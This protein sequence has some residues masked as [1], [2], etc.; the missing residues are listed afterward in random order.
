MSIVNMRVGGKVKKLQ[1][2][3]SFPLN[4]QEKTATKNGEV[5]ADEGYAGLSK[6]AVNVPIPE[7]YIKP[8]GTKT[9]TANGTHDVSG[10]ASA[11]VNV[12]TSGGGGT[13][14]CSGTHLI[15]VTE[16]PTEN[17]D[18]NAVYYIDSGTETK[19]FTDVIMINSGTA[20]SVRSTEGLKS[21]YC[22]TK[23]TE[24]LVNGTYYYV[25]DEDTVY[26]YMSRTLVDMKTQFNYLGVIS[27]ASQA[28][29]DVD[30]VYVVITTTITEDLCFY[31]KGGDTVLTDLVEFGSSGTMSYKELFESLGATVAIHSI[32]TRISEGIL[33]STELVFNLYYIQN[34]NVA[35]MFSGGQWGNTNIPISDIVSNISEVPPVEGIY[36]IG[37]I[38]D[39]SKYLKPS[40]GLDITKNDFYDVADKASVS[41]KI[42]A[43]YVVQTVADL[44]D[45]VLNGDLAIVLS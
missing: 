19:S 27:S 6:V 7:G 29:T 8:T 30:G 34:E 17:I 16:L 28:S 21:V 9:I 15:E 26:G 37:T 3:E 10:Y 33:E 25:E 5:V 11:E 2:T 35:D 43:Y 32:P 44:P 18:E 4:L 20:T 41:V 42:P 31:K 12:P 45:V 36:L 38:G 39:W 1:L 13:G 40:G 24:N 14:E 22:T 23:P